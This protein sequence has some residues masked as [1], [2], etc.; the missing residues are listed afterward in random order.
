MLQGATAA[1]LFFGGAISMPALPVLSAIGGTKDPS[2]TGSDDGVL[3]EPGDDGGSPMAAP[4]R[5]RL[6]ASDSS[7]PR[8]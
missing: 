4:V 2:G 6:S 1:A 3:R 8:A 5:A 7:A